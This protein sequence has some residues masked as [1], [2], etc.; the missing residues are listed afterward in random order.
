M[1]QRARPLLPEAE[2]LAGTFPLNGSGPNC[3]GNV[4]AAAGVPGADATRIFPETFQQWLDE[5]TEPVRG[6]TCDR[7]PGTVLYWTEHDRLAHAAVTIG[8]GW[9]LNKPSQSWSSPRFV[10]A[11]TEVIHR[12]RSPGPAC[13]GAGSPADRSGAQRTGGGPTDSR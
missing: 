3:F 1:W 4:L 8:D 12:W 9:L 10:L 5:H 2:R 6:T 13:T 7:E 11:V